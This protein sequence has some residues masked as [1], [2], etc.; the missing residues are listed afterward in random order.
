MCVWKFKKISYGYFSSVTT[1]FI[2]FI[3]RH[4]RSWP[5]LHCRL[6]GHFLVCTPIWGMARAQYSGI[7]LLR[8]V[9]SRYSRPYSQSGSSDVEYIAVR[10]CLTSRCGV[11]LRVS[12]QLVYFVGLVVLFIELFQWLA[13]W[14]RYSQHLQMLTTETERLSIQ[15][16]YT[17][18]RLPTY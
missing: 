4:F 18:W 6:A 15:Q 11:W 5:R 12:Q 10:T 13:T 8:L 1:L 7:G 17:S 3:I 2:F 16:A 14:N 9:C